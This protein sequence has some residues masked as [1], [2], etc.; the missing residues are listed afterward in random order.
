MLRP[1][2]FEWPAEVLALRDRVRA[3]VAEEVIPLEAQAGEDGLAAQALEA[4]RRKARDAGLWL[5]QLPAE[6]GGLGLGLLE[7]CPIFEEAGRSL[8]GPLALN[9]SAPDEGTM[10]LLLRFATLEQK[11]RYLR[12]LAEGRLRSTFA[13]TE[14]APG[15]GSDPSMLQTRARRDGTE[16]VINGRKWFASG[17]E[18]AAF[19]VVAALTDPEATKAT[20]FL[21]DA[22][23]P[24]YRVVRRIPTMGIGIPGGHCEVALEGCRVASAQVLG[25]PGQGFRLMQAR[26]GPA[27]LTHCMR[28]LGVA[29]RSLEIATA[30]ARERRAFGSPLG[31]HE[32][33]QWMLADS[34]IDIHSSRLMIQHAAWRIE[35]GDE[36]RAETSTCKVHVAEAVGRVVDR[37]VQVCGSL[38]YST[39]LPL[40]A[41]Y[42]EVRAFRIYDGPSEVHRRVI[43]RELL[44]G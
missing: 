39:D 2:N 30:R 16:W 20:L 22:D 37:A 11:E 23:T 3:F 34:A 12:P 40:E 17:A 10:H 14:P 18:G 6:Y 26:L 8:L 1:M 42:R 13:M 27:R 25:A 33:V 4:V 44:K 36:A 21:V 41:F 19:A 38:G 32:A 43:A 29:Q 15:A 5:P 9:C 35:Q 31:E 7:L 28:W 24:G